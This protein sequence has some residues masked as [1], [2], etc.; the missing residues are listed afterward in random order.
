MQRITELPA[1]FSFSKTRGGLTAIHDESGTVLHYS[2][3]EE[4]A[5]LALSCHER[6]G[7]GPGR[8]HKVDA[9]VDL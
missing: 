2:L 5:L 3:D 8:A 7:G 6:F 4:Q 9:H 1:G